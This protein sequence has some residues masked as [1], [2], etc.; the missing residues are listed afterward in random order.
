MDAWSNDGLQSYQRFTAPDEYLRLVRDQWIQARR[1][2]DLN[3]Q[4]AVSERK[5]LFSK[6]FG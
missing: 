6:L 2:T 3:H 4:T 5:G 1:R